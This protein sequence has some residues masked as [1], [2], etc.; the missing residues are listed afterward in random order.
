MNTVEFLRLVLPSRGLYVASRLTL[1]GFR[2]HVCDTIEELAQQVLSYDAQEVAAYY[3]CS[4]YRERSVDGVKD[5]KPIKQ[6]RT[7]KNVRAARDYWM[8]LDVKPGNP[9]AFES[10][11]HAL[12]ALVEFCRKVDI[13]VPTIISS[14]YGLQIHWTV[15]N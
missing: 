2:N 7:H 5:G 15:N 14:G 13:P 3:A 11:E 8:D 12:V 9:A 10:Q 4:A 6:V 1:K